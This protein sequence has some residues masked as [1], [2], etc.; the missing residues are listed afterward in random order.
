LQSRKPPLSPPRLKA[1]NSSYSYWRVKGIQKLK[2]GTK[3]KLIAML[4]NEF[5]PRCTVARKFELACISNPAPNIP[6]SSC[7]AFESSTR[8]SRRI[9][10]ALQALLKRF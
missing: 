3:F 2:H 9:D 1:G 10:F 7:R 8:C 4:Q 6:R 5:R